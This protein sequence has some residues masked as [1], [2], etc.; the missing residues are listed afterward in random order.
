MHFGLE[1]RCLCGDGDIP[2]ILK[3]QTKNEQQHL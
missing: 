3:E 2:L 1:K